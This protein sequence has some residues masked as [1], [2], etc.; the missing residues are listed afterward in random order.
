M[1]GPVNKTAVDELAGAGAPPMANGELIF[2]APWQSRVFGM[3]R[4]LC[5]S[6]VY[7]WDEFRAVLIENIAAWET[8]HK[9]EPYAYFDIFLQ[10]L[11]SLLDARQLCSVDELASLQQAFAERPHGHDH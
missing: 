4:V 9:D 10:T 7:D 2:E 11:A 6:G 1:S 3:A 5:E 8:T